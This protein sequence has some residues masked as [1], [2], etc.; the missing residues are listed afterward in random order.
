MG[1]ES[2]IRDRVALEGVHLAAVARG[3]LDAHH[4][5]RALVNVLTLVLVRVVSHATVVHRV[6]LSV[7]QVAG[8]DVMLDAQ[9]PPGGR[10][11]IF[12]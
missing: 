7:K 10:T 2:C 6:V 3:V 9:H 4:A 11:P 8:M 12:C 5:H 1:W